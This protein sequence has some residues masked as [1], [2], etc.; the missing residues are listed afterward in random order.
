[1]VARFLGT[2]VVIVGY[3]LLSDFDR[4][5]E[6]R[7]RRK[8]LDKLWDEEVSGWERKAGSPKGKIG[9]LESHSTPSSEAN[10]SARFIVSSYGGLEMQP[11]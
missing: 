11:A 9:Q 6:R 3:S 2:V 8:E 10:V 7:Q 1:L 5:L 4:W